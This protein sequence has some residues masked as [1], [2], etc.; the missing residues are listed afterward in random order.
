[1]LL[2]LAATVAYLETDQGDLHENSSC[3][4]GCPDCFFPLPSKPRR[5]RIPP[6]IREAD[7]QLGSADIPAHG[8]GEE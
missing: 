5:E 4:L 3:I 1:M 7:K 6:G 8:A 2:N